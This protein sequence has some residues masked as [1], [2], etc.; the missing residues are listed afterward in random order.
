ML[1]KEPHPYTPLPTTING[2]AYAVIVLLAAFCAWVFLSQ[3]TIIPDGATES[4][5]T[6][7]RVIGVG[8]AAFWSAGIIC[9]VHTVY[10]RIKVKML[11]TGKP[12]SL[13]AM[14]PEG[15]W[16]FVSFAGAVLWALVSAL[17][18]SFF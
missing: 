9:W 8:F 6:K 14:W 11:I 15:K 17:V 18:V 16:L 13:T 5:G 7:F 4:D 2:L 1:H 10:R 12:H 3:F